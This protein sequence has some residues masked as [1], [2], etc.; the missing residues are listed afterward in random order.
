METETMD[1]EQLATYLHRDVREVSKM[2][3]RGHLPG[4]KVGGQWR[5]ASAEI[6][7]W[8]ETQLHGYS[9]EQ[10][11]ALET[12]AAQ[13]KLENKPLVTA[14]LSESTMAVPLA[15]GTKASV[16]R[17]LVRL[18][19]LSWHVYDAEALL[20]AIRLREDMDSTALAGGVAIPHP[21]R[22]L[23]TLL[24]DSVI[25]YGRTAAPVPFGSPDGGLSD[26]FFLICCKNHRTHLQVLARLARMLLRATF[27]D[28][29]RA[30][31]TVQETWHILEAAEKDLLESA[32]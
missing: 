32:S 23:P 21:R 11:T 29:L 19:E 5:F 10:L 27:A 31:G 24:G 16:L 4:Q 25:A 12:G 2:A 3:S 14:L 30:A 6:N 22:P 18:A 8:I 15:A 13:G 17:E 7:Y 20:A 1:L 9:E 26:I 28:D